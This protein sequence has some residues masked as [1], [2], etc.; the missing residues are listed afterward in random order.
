MQVPRMTVPL[1]MI[2][3]GLSIVLVTVGI[4]L[5]LGRRNSTPTRDTGE[6]QAGSS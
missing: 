1:I 6:S 5:L 2:L 3:C 4:V